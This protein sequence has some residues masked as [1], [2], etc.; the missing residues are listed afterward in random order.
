MTDVDLQQLA[1]DRSGWAQPSVRTRRQMLTRYVL[2]AVL[3]AGFLALIAWAARDI[4]FPARRVTVVPVFAMQAELGREGTPLFKAAGWI[5]PRPTPVRVAALAPGVVEQLLVVEDQLVKAGQPVAEL[6]KDDA[7]LDLERAQADFKLREAEMDEAQAVFA[8]AKTRFE[9]PVHLQAALAEAEAALAKI[10]RELKGLPFATR[11]AEAQLEFAKKDYEGK[12]SA[13]GTVAGRAIDAARSELDSAQALVEELCVRDVALQ[14]E[15]S[16]HTERRNALK[17]QRELLTDEIKAKDAGEAQVKAAAARLQQA[18]VV[19]AIARLRLDRMTVRAPI[20]GRV[21][22][23]IGHPGSRMGSSMTQMPGH[24][25]S[26]VVTLYRPSLL[27]VR[28]DVRFQDLPQVSL[29][30]PVQIENPALPSPLTG[31]VLFPSSLADIQKNT[32]EVKVAI[33]DPPPVFKPEMLVDVTFLAPKPAEPA[34]GPSKELR[35]YV[36]QSLVKQ[37]DRGKFIWLVDQSAGAARRTPVQTGAV[38]SNGL[39]EVTGRLTISS[40]IIAGGTDG[41]QDGDRVR[42][43]GEESALAAGQMLPQ[44]GGART[45]MNRLPTAENK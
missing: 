38:G 24:D 20:G 13:K 29:G 14:Q 5:E 41:L 36:P 11:R 23:L 2:P 35:Y 42:V 15:R 45:S 34:S 18:C 3:I 10:E 37:D 17:K 1:I 25:G 44:S 39:V 26:T 6:V 27:Q 30:Q 7:M 16:A 12:R 4:L 43:T 33:D 8:A 40:R 28:V 21:Y 9:Q 22:K 31:T 19:V 32:L